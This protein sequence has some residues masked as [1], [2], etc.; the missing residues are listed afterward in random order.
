VYNGPRP[1]K[2]SQFEEIPSVA[3]GMKII[4]KLILK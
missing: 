1:L 2:V 3:A 4:N